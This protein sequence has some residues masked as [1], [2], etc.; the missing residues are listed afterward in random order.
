MSQ[1]VN[2]ATLGAPAD[3]RSYPNND[4]VTLGTFESGHLQQSPA[5]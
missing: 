2:H 4:S 1:W 3:V 5:H